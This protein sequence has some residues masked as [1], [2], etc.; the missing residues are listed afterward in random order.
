MGQD[1]GPFQVRRV[2]LH[3]NTWERVGTYDTVQE[4]LSKYNELV[5][6]YRRE[7]AFV[8]NLRTGAKIAD[9]RER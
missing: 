2:R 9:N 1:K 8:V 7:H 5:S 6:D 3:S 4:A